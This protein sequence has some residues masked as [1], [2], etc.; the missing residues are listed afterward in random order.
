MQSTEPAASLDDI[1]I[2]PVL[3]ERRAPPRD[4]VAEHEAL[5]DLIGHAAI[6][7]SRLLPRLVDLAVR[8]CHA[9]SAGV[10]LLE[11]AAESAQGVFRW[12]A[13]AGAY[14]EYV[15]GTTPESFSPCG[16]CLDRGSPQL[17]RYPSRL[18]TYLAAASPPIVEGLV[19]PLRS[20]A[21]PLGTIWIVSHDEAGA[22]TSRD[23]LVM[24]SLAD[25]T[26]TA[27][28]LQRARDE[29]QAANRAKD[30]FLAV[31]SHEL[32]RPLTAIVG[33][34]ELLLAGRST[35]ATA[36]RA[37]AALY[38]NAR[39]QQDMIEDL[40]D[41]SRALTGS[42]RL[43]EQ[44]MDVTAVVRSAIEV[45]AD[46]AK[47]RGVEL[48][49]D[50]A[51]SL[52]VRG[53]PERLHQVVGNLLSNA[54]KFTAAGG[55]VSVAVHKA[56]PWIEI[57]VEDTGIGI[58]PHMIPLVFDAFCKVDASSTR[59]ESGL[60]LGLT[61]ARRLTALHDG[62][63]DA[64]SDG[65]G[66]GARFIVRLPAT[67]LITRSELRPQAAVL[68]KRSLQLAG[69]TILVVDDEPDVREILVCVLEDAGATLVAVADVEGALSALASQRI[70]V[71]VTDLVMPGQ[72][73]YDLLAR[74]GLSAV[75]ARPRTT[76]AV[77]ALA[78]ARDRLR[79]LAAGFDHHVA[80]PVNFP[81]LIQLI[82][83][84]SNCEEA[85]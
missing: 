26:S 62:T 34:S 21:G 37:I 12:V 17:Y 50:L 59:R 64:H 83:A 68:T 55:R 78:S 56:G 8:L 29:A 5:T 45:V 15:G 18:F 48:S 61:I 80:K 42:L 25:F 7:P 16:V 24:A 35:P 43:N 85:R 73:G 31:V 2:T 20:E 74:I 63:V 36:A 53:D 9:G 4:I 28:A 39:R 47:Q 44:P 77:T 14:R 46:R 51:G 82:V 19:L 22:F 57:S 11:P 6:D 70:D 60:G 75:P 52:T 13:M 71:L 23:V 33:W 30:E 79:V 40:L 65:P 66:K 72:D 67:R 27:L 41:A 58:A 69:V 3:A 84:S 1:V 54:V 76:I 49:A 10:S 38:A 32:R 81:A